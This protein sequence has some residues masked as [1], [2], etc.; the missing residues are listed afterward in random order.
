MSGDVLKNSKVM[1]FILAE[2]EKNTFVTWYIT[3]VINSTFESV[4]SAKQWNS[5]SNLSIGELNLQ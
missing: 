5:K 3:S 1:R 2:C 4:I